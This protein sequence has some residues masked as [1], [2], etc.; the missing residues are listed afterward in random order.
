MCFQNSNWALRQPSNLF[1]TKLDMVLPICSDLFTSGVTRAVHMNYVAMRQ[2]SCRVDTSSTQ[3][4]TTSSCL[5]Q[6][7]KGIGVGVHVRYITNSRLLVREYQP[8]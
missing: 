5:N 6:W 8:V 7:V 1:Q 2:P 4:E 3:M